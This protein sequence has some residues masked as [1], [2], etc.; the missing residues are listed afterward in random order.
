MYLTIPPT[1]LLLYYAKGGYMRINAI[2]TFSNP[3]YRKRNQVIRKT[4][5]T[6]LQ[7]TK[8][9]NDNVTFKGLIGKIGGGGIGAGI[10]GLCAIASMA[11]PVGWLAIATLVASEAGGAVLGGIIGDKIEDKDED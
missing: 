11:T 5:F 7:H 1:L 6:N 8:S 3:D 4:Q 10:A 9:S 2:N